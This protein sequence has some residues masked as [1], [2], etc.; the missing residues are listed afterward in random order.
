MIRLIPAALLFLA[1]CQ[2]SSDIGSSPQNDMVMI[3]AGEF[4]MGSP[5]DGLS[6]DDER[7]QRTVFVS[8]FRIDRDR[9]SVV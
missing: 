3:P 8:S 5:D 1:A 7:P 2:T 6:F 4:L 9:K